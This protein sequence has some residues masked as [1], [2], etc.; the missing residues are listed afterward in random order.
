MRLATLLFVLAIATSALAGSF[1]ES[2][3]HGVTMLQARRYEE[4]A[5]SFL[6]AREADPA[7][8]P[9]RKGLAAAWSGLGTERLHAGRLRESR[10]LL[11]KAVE[12]RPEAADLHLLLAQV[13]FRAGDV[14]GARREVDLALEITPGN[15]VARDLSGDLY[16]HEGRLNL[17]VGEWE[18]A[19][20]A[21]RTRSL[22]EKIE[23]GR[24][25]MI[26][27]EGMERETSRFF[28]VQFDSNVPRLL[29][30]AIFKLLDDS[31]NFMHDQL[32][33]YPRDAI[34]VL[35]Y[36]QQAFRDVTNAPVWAGGLYDGKIRIPV[37]NLR[38]EGA[39][40]LPSLLKIL[41]EVYNLPATLTHEM[42]H[43]FVSRM[44]PAGLPLWFNEGL[45]TTFE[46]WDPAKVREWLAQNAPAAFA[47]LDDIDRGL[48]GRSGNVSAAYGAARLA[49]NEIIEIRGAGAVR[50]IL[51]G[52]GDGRPFPDVFADEVR[53]DLREFEE[54]W[55]KGLP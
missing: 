20:A 35:L 13:Q 31:F 44:A 21:G 47:S 41:T 24:G 43:A 40:D 28:V 53:L 42:A 50:G 7:S 4:A 46:G 36:S 17:A 33:D 27:E 2:M 10:A 45:A 18:V 39:R 37:G 23:R 51:K 8:E 14:A 30:Q 16:Y 49:I 5:A 32:G 15:A 55:R 29:V 11:E 1:S 26:A 48:Q 9:A 3:L 19:A 38:I 6:E 54:R 52:V 22:S 12:I 25:D 34:Q